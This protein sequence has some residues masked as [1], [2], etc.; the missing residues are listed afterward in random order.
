MI[1]RTCGFLWNRLDAESISSTSFRSMRKALDCS[2]G[3]S[4]LNRRFVALKKF[5]L[6]A[7]TVVIRS[8]STRAI[9][10][11]LYNIIVDPETKGFTVYL[12]S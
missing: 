11:S 10:N 4:R 2:G 7:V 6:A 12:N 1:F 9:E 8:A 3:I 5:D